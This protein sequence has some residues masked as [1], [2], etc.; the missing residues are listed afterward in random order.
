LLTT[1]NKHGQKRRRAWG[2]GG[3]GMGWG[4]VGVAPR[5]PRGGWRHRGGRRGCAGSA[6]PGPTGSGTA[7]PHRSRPA[8]SLHRSRPDATMERKTRKNKERG[9]H[10]VPALEKISSSWVTDMS[11]SM[12]VSTRLPARVRGP[13]TRKDP[14]G[15][16][17]SSCVASSRST[18]G[19]NQPTGGE[20]C[21]EKGAWASA[22]GDVG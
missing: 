6:R 19:R 4:E 21:S 14:A 16:P 12:A 2:G 9:A 22:L 3:E 11:G 8:A 1:G 18:W 10:F 20:T 13:R 17:A 15:L 5:W 7:A